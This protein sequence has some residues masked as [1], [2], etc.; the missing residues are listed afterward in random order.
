MTAAKQWSLFGVDLGRGGDWFALAVRQLLWSVDGGVYPRLSEP[1]V[2]WREDDSRQVAHESGLSSG[3]EDQA[4]LVTAVELPESLCLLRTL[5]LPEAA[6]AD[7]EAAVTYEVQANS[8][9]PDDD[10]GFGWRIV[11]R[12]AETLDIA[13]VMVSLAAANAWLRR[14]RDTAMQQSGTEVWAAVAPQ[15]YVVLP[16][17][18]ESVRRAR[19]RGTLRQ[20]TLTAAG[21][22]LAWTCLLAVPAVATSLR[23]SQLADSLS[24]VVSEARVATELRETVGQQQSVLQA[25]AA[26]Q[27]QRVH[28]DRWMTRLAELAPDSV[29]FYHLSFEGRRVEISGLAENAASFLNEMAKTGEFTALESPSAFTRDR[30]TGRERF[31]ITMDLPEVGAP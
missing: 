22:L 29:Y 27:E 24:E 6:E 8:P 21:V 20:I 9:F 26:L 14:H 10:V 5:S 15:R 12:D 25:L 4:D 28:H 1:V 23:A 31:T 18:G 30:A 2:L 19:Y 7:L 13:I 11:R 16:G 17:F 3:D